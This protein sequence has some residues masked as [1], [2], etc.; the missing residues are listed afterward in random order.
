MYLTMRQT[1]V[2][3]DSVLD[4]YLSVESSQCEDQWM[5]LQLPKVHQGRG[6][7]LGSVTKPIRVRLESQSE[8]LTV[9]TTWAWLSGVEVL[10]WLGPGL[11][12]SP[13][14]L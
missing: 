8:G 11:L 1:S 4:G 2:P 12:E 3:M 10:P 14:I 7:L 9:D 5:Y 13:G 6:P